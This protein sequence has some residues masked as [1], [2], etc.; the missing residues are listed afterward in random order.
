M[1]FHAI[2]GNPQTNTPVRRSVGARRRCP[3]PV[4]AAHQRARPSS[5][6]SAA[7]AVL[8]GTRSRWCEKKVLPMDDGPDTQKGR[9]K[10]PIGPTVLRK[11]LRGSVSLLTS[12]IFQWE[13][14]RTT[15]C[16]GWIGRDGCAACVASGSDLGPPRTSL[17][18]GI[19]ISFAFKQTS[20]C[21]PAHPQ[22]RCR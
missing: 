11:G 9:R 12:G 16:L 8:W 18:Y 21:P 2:I 3:C 10:T 20:N 15:A 19:M 5:T 6:P 17:C 1:L 13:P 4:L 22:R 14:G 7:P